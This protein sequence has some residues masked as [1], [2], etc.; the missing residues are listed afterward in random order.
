[1]VVEHQCSLHLPVFRESQVMGNFKKKI[2]SKAAASPVP[3]AETLR[4][5]EGRR[6]NGA[7]TGV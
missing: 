3:L 2:T 6:V 1:L 7:V 4:V 5:M